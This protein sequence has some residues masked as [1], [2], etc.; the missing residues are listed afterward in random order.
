VSHRALVFTGLLFWLVVIAASL[1]AWSWDPGFEKR[2]HNL[3]LEEPEGFVVDLSSVAESRLGRMRW[4]AP[5]PLELRVGELEAQDVLELKLRSECERAQ[6]DVE[7]D[8]ARIGSL[9]V[10]DRWREQKVEVPAP[11]SMLTLRFAGVGV[12]CDVHVS[13]IYS[14]NLGGEAEDLDLYLVRGGSRSPSRIAIWILLLAPLVL[15]ARPPAPIAVS[16]RPWRRRTLLPASG[17]LAMGVMHLVAALRGL[18]VVQP[19]RSVLA[20][21]IAT[22]LLLVAGWRAAG[23]LRRHAPLAL[24][25]ARRWMSGIAPRT[26]SL[27]ALAVGAVVW[28]P[29]L[30]SI[31]QRHFDSD[32][33]GFARFGERWARAEVLDDVPKRGYGHEGQFYAVLAT[34]PFLRRDD[35]IR[36]LD[37]PAYR[38]RRVLVSFVAWCVALGDGGRAL[39]TYV[40]V[41]WLTTLWAVGLVGDWLARRR[42]SPLFTLALAF[43][44]GVAVCIGRAM[45]DGGAAALVILA[46]VCW[47]RG[48]RHTALASA[49]AATLAKETSAIVALALAWDAWRRGR[50]VEAL[51]LPLVPIVSLVLWLVYVQVRVQRGDLL[52]SGTGNFDLP[53]SWLVPKLVQLDDWEVP[54]VRLAES[55]ALLGLLVAFILTARLLV[56]WRSLV[57]VETTYVGLMLLA[58]VMSLKVYHGIFDYSRVLVLVPLLAAMVAA[59][60]RERSVRWLAWTVVG[61]WVVSGL[62]LMT[63]PI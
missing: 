6:V 40:L 19:P 35:T 29:L 2:V 32:L 50:R 33:R 63:T 58:S 52:H 46:L 11:G 47:S 26:R 39:V 8:G 44:A 24:G 18:R 17:L 60:R 49:T 25:R 12:P 31:A 37:T 4:V 27:L 10:E 42:E 9:I 30:V 62:S 1:V 56:H 57:P 22:P 45:P 16:L 28:I 55:S 21:A 20:V 5:R 23:W 15:L 48:R 43:Q 13:K 53:F 59:E 51:L 61:L 14:T 38:A 36:S 41:C 3:R 54:A 34:D 7:V